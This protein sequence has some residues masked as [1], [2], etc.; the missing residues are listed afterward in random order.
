MGV[1]FRL[2]QQRGLVKTEN[3]KYFLGIQ[4]LSGRA[5]DE[6][7]AVVT[8]RNRACS[9]QCLEVTRVMVSYLGL[10]LKDVLSHGSL[11]IF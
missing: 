9:S 5:S 3:I 8:P 11:I 10:S 2:D 4:L 6:G 7:A 1:Y